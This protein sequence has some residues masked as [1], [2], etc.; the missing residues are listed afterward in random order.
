MSISEF[1]FFPDSTQLAIY[2]IYSKKYNAGFAK[3]INMLMRHILI[4]RQNQPALFSFFQGL[5]IAHN[6]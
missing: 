4:N 1:L 5:P 3:H 2:A 6:I